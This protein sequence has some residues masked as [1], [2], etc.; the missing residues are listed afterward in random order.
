MIKVN[1]IKEQIKEISDKYNLKLVLLFGSQ[2][3][4]RR[5]HKES[6]IDIAF[7]PVK[8]LS[9]EEEYFLNYDLTNIFRTDKIDTVNLKN[10]PPLLMKE[11]IDNCQ[12][13]YESEPMVF[14]YFDA[15]VRQ[16]YREAAPLFKLHRE[17]IRRFVGLPK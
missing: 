5:I 8:K 16:R 14:D 1:Q 9:P 3:S 13:I 4:G 7:L 10:T 11:I 12:I 15:Y 6:D 2:A 17:S